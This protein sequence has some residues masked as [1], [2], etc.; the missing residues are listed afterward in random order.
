MRKSANGLSIATLAILAE[1]YAIHYDDWFTA[2]DIREEIIPS[3]DLNVPSKFTVT[4]Y[5]C[6][7]FER[8]DDTKGKFKLTA[9]AV[10][11]I[12]YH[13]VFTCKR[14]AENFQ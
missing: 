5:R 2:K 12:K 11:I 8:H 9:K 14:I 3:L 10:E 1:I 4:M 13:G 7:F 6:G